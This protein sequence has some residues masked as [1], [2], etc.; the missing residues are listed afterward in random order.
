[1]EYS[2][3]LSLTALL[4]AL[5]STIINYLVLRSQKDPEVIIYAVHDERR[6]SIINLIIKN[7]G[8]GM[9]HDVKF[10]PNRWI[11]AR[12]FG[13]NETKAMK[14]QEMTNGPLI[15]GIPTLAA[16]EK[17]IITWGQY[18]GLKIGLGDEVLNIK[19][20]YY[21]RPPLY[22]KRQRHETTSGLDIRSFE[23]TDASD[24]NWDRKSAENIE[25]IAKAITQLID[26]HLG[27][28]NITIKS[29]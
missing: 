28:L 26:S 21:S 19:A 11:P 3:I 13:L 2:E 24:N 16:G 22:L 12:A 23:G 20:T 25:I 10:A 5:T 8:K 14:P 17:R 18:G 1:M 29:R 6:P 4:I 9:A 27:A 15:S 7:S